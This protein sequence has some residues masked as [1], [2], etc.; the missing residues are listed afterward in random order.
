M[1]P[2]L[3]YKI[4]LNAHICVWKHKCSVDICRCQ[5]LENTVDKCYTGCRNHLKRYET[6]YFVS[7][8][9]KSSGVSATYSIFLLKTRSVMRIEGHLLDK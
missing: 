3:Y 6:N 2:I 7:Y 1:L 8:H 4:S 9:R 5:M